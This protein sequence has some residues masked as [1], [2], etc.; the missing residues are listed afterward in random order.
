MDSSTVN[1][2]QNTCTD[3]NLSFA[4][5]EEVDIYL[6]S[7]PIISSPVHIPFAILIYLIT[8]KY[9]LPKFME[10]RQPYNLKNIIL[11]YNLVQVIICTTTCYLYFKYKR[12]P[13]TALWS[14]VCH[15]MSGDEICDSSVFINIVNLEMIYYLNKYMDL[16]DTVFFSLRKKYS[17]VSF[18]HVY[19]HVI[20]ILSTWPTVFIFKVEGTAFLV[21]LNMF[22]HVVMYSYYFL[23]S[24][25][26]AV[27]KYLWWK[28]YLTFLQIIQ[29]L[30]ALIFLVQLYLKGCA[31]FSY[32]FLW[33]FTVVTILLLFLNF[34]KRTY[35]K[36]VI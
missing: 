23:S 27:Q 24:F 19:H 25:G 26:P 15:H 36:K 5:N 30:I 29:F 28:R 7:I 13:I 1:Y 6:A 20:V 22:I 12:T 10:N 18:L 34:Y 9:I 11:I 35:K 32:F 8:V 33:T 2:F 4:N 21:T 31:D 17:Q 3:K 14:N 16:L